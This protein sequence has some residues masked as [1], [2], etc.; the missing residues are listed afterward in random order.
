MPIWLCRLTP[1]LFIVF[2]LVACDKSSDEE[3]LAQQITVIQKAV[4]MKDFSDIETHLHN[5][6]RANDRLSTNEMDQLLRMY[7]TRHKNIGVMIV[8][9][10]T[11][12]DSTFT[13]R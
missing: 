6:L 11:T 13:D 7:S 5:D 2:I 12:L 1:L 8:A 3:Q 9:N 10:S 4:E